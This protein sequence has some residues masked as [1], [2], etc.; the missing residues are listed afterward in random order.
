M[1]KKSIDDIDV[2]NKRVLTRVDFNVPLDDQGA[3]TDDRRIRMALPTIQSILERGGSAIL[4]SHLGRPAG[5]GYEPGLS[6]ERAAVR[7]GELLNRPVRFPSHDC[8]DDEASAAVTALKTGEVVVLENLRFHEGEKKGDAAFADRLA[9]FGDVYCNDAFGT[10]HREDASMVAVPKAMGDRPRVAGML[11]QREL[12]YL[13]GAIEQAQ[14]PFVAVLGGAKVSDK[15]GALMHLIERVDAILVGGA[16]A[17]TLLQAQGVSIGDSLVE[18]D[19]VDQAKGILD[20]AAAQS[21]SLGLPGDHVC[22]DAQSSQ[23]LR[24]CGRQIP[25]GWMGMDIGPRSGAQFVQQLSGAKTVVWNG[26]MGVFETPPFDVG[27]KL[28]A[29]MLAGLTADGA[30]T[31]VGGGDSAA[32]VEACGLS[33]AV[34]H[35]STG[36]GASLQMLEGR[37]FASVEVLDGA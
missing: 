20:A 19:M 18:S 36:G 11:L 24:V 27:T 1:H 12:T 17:Y 34:S 37:H 28:I 23:D 25:E 2:T 3:I 4:M 35:V 26:P 14:R 33:G 15:L 21:T 8:I 22:R 32:A 6:L 7:L 9:A 30:T 16:M 13:S 29:Q 10:S 31:I 5:Q